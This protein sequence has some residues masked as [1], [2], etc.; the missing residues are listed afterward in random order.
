MI[1]RISYWVLGITS[2]ALLV[3]GLLGGVIPGINTHITFVSTESIPTGLYWAKK[4]DTRVQI[5]RGD[6]VCARYSPP[7]WAA[8]RKYARP[9][10]GICKLVVGIPGDIVAP[11]ID[12]I[13]ICNASSSADCTVVSPIQKTDRKNRP[14]PQYWTTTA[15]L[16]AGDYFLVGT[17]SPYSLDSR[18]LGPLN[19]G[20]IYR[21]LA[22]LYVN[23]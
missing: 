10:T 14:I 17:K 12:A 20:G 21:M 1:N 7:A 2:F 19:K 6:L 16:G 15:T 5:Q 4:I 22:P 8:D 13:K 23:P 11:T 9:G 18:Y 3:A